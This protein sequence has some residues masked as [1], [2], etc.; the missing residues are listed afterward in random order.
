MKADVVVVGAGL[1][2]NA[3]AL[4]AAESGATVLLLEKQSHFGGS[5]ILAGGGLAFAGTDLQK[6]LRI[7][8]SVESLER[9]LLTSGAGR[10]DPQMLRAY[11]DHQLATFYWL[12]EHGVKFKLAPAAT[13][14]GINRI[15]GTE[16]GEAARALHDHVL[17]HPR[18]K[19]V[20]NARGRRLRQ[21]ARGRVVGLS[22]EVEGE[23]VQVDADRGVVL[24]SGGF[25]HNRE[26]L[27]VFAPQWVDAIAM[28]GRGNTG[29]GF[30]MACAVGAGLA[31][32]A[33]IEAT[34][35][36][37]L[38][39]YPDVTQRPDSDPSLLF[40]IVRGAILVNLDAQRFSNEALNYKAL[41][42][43]GARQRDGVAFQVFDQ[44]VMDRSLASPAPANYKAAYSQGIVR[45][46]PNL[47]ALAAELG[48]DGAQLEAT[49]ER[50][51][52][53][54]AKGIDPD[55]GRPIPDYGVAGGACVDTP[56]FYAFPCAAALTTTY[57][58]IRTDAQLR[59]RNVFD[60]PIDGLYAAGEVTG[61][62]HGAAYLS[63]TALGKA[64]VHG[65]LAGISCASNNPT[66]L[67]K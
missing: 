44:K 26:L 30:L 45:G 7:G 4:A 35:G 22:A 42:A 39:R 54:A 64:A 3:A 57:C 52:A 21:D 34:L 37:S 13:R 23:A 28:G 16:M 2:G 47:A 8:D 14:R 67:S 33:Y 25:V 63:G 46:A 29:D 53:N 60:E 17:K 66:G 65:R 55:Q 1:A 12:R 20:C 38:D 32:M 9:D 51:N 18:V 27:Q 36:A 61:G 10:N 40:P 31:D 50:Y 5:S 11:L 15:H 6:D 43:A 48:I 49:V 59:V 41:G 58:G 24:A 19:Y 62:F 56:P